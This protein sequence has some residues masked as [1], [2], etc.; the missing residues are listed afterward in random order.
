MY[1]VVF[2]RITTNRRYWISNLYIYIYIYIYISPHVIYILYR[3]VMIYC[4]RRDPLTW[5]MLCTL[6]IFMYTFPFLINIVTDEWSCRQTHKRQLYAL[7]WTPI[8]MKIWIM[9]FIYFTH[10]F[11]LFRTLIYIFF[12]FCKFQMCGYILPCHI[13][14]YYIGLRRTAIYWISKLYI[15]IYIIISDI[16]Y[17]IGLWWTI[18][19]KK[20]YVYV[21]YFYIYFSLYNYYC[22]GRTDKHIYTQ[23]TPKKQLWIP[24]IWNIE[25]CILFICT[26][27]FP[28][29]RT[30][31][32]IFPLFWPLYVLSMGLLL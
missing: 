23:M 21:I 9:Y 12:L 28:L 2:H 4:C 27:T 16:L 26:C 29:F 25:L 6:F 8:N 5:K 31:T 22:D 11:P 19:I 13:Y 20:I 10:A 7:S 24:F 14:I 30:R 15:Y 17:C 3:I 32:Y 1:T 18:F